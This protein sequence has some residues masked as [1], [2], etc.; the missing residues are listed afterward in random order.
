MS[1]LIEVQIVQILECRKQQYRSSIS[2]VLKSNIPPDTDIEQVQ[3][4]I[5]K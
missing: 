4:T 1:P 2:A 3:L 5:P